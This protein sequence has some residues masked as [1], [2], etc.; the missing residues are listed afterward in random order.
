MMI[1]S[2]RGLKLLLV[3]SLAITALFLVSMEDATVSGA[4][5]TVDDDGTG[6]FRT[7]Q[8]AIDAANAGDT[9]SVADGTYDVFDVTK[10]VNIF[11]TGP[12]GCTI[13]GIG[14]ETPINITANNVN[15]SGFFI[16]FSG[17]HIY[18]NGSTIFK[19]YFESN[20]A[21]VYLTMGTHHS[22]IKNND[23]N[24]NNGASTSGI[25]VYIG[26]HN[27]TFLHNRLWENEYGIGLIESHNN[28]ISGN[29][30]N[31]S[32]ESGIILDDSNDTQITQNVI[33][34][35]LRG[36]HIRD[37]SRTDISSSLIHDNT[38]NGIHFDGGNGG[39][40][41]KNIIHDN[42]NNG[43]LLRTSFGVKIYNNSI[44][45]NDRGIAL[46][47]QSENNV[48][49]FNNI[50]NNVNYGV[51]DPSTNGFSINASYNW[52]GD[53]TGPYHVDDNPDGEGD[54]VSDDVEFITW[55]EDPI[56]V[57]MIISITENPAHGDYKVRFEGY[58]I[59]EEINF[60][61]WNSSIDGEFYKGT[62][63]VFRN[64]QLSVGTHLISFRVR[65]KAGNIWSEDIN[66][67][68]VIHER[69]MPTID[70]VSPKPALDTDAILFRGSGTDDGTIEQYAWRSSI[71][72]EFYNGT[73]PEFLYD[74]LSNGSHLIY[75]KVMDNFGGWSDEVPT[76]LMIQGRPQVFIEDISP[77]PALFGDEI[78]FT[79]RADDDGSITRIIWNSSISGTLS[80]GLDETIWND[81]LP[82]GEHLITIVAVDD[83]DV[84]SFE[85]SFTAI[86]TLKPE[87]F[88]DSISPETA[89]DTDVIHFKGHGTDGDGA[90][91]WFEW[92]S[93]L[94][95]LLYAG[96]DGEFGDS[97]LRNGTHE[98]TLRVMDNYGVWSDAVSYSITVFGKPI[99]RISTIFPNP[100]I[101]GR[102]VFF[103][104]SG[105]DE[106]SILQFAWRSN[107]DGEF[108]N[109]TE[110]EFYFANLSLGTH[111]IFFKVMDNDGIWSSEVAKT[112]IITSIP[113]AI[114]NDIS[115]NPAFDTDTITFNG[116]GT[117]DRGIDRYSWRSDTDGEFY[118]GTNDIIMINGLSNGTHMI[119]LAVMDDLGFWST[120][121]N[122]TL[123]IHGKPRAHIISVR[124]KPASPEDN[125][126]F[127]GGGTDDGSIVR[128]V[129]TSSIQGE[130]YN[131]TDDSFT[132]TS[133]LRGH[134]TISIKV[135]DD[136]GFWSD[137]DST[138]LIV[139]DIPIPYI[140][141]I[142]PNPA[143]HVET[144][145]FEGH[146][147]DNGNIERYVW[148]SDLDGE[149]Y[150]GTET[151]LSPFQM[152]EGF[153]AINLSYGTGGYTGWFS[154]NSTAFEG[155]R[156]ARS[157]DVDDDEFSWMETTFS[158]PG[159]LSFFWKVSSEE[160][161]HLRLYIDG[162]YTAQISGN[163]DWA[164]YVVTFED[165]GHTV[166]WSYEKDTS[167]SFGADAGYVD[168]I[169]Y[170]SDLR[171]Q[172]GTHTITLTVMDNEGFWSKT[173]SSQLVINGKPI[174]TDTKI[175]P[176]PAFHTDP[177]TFNATVEEDGNVT[178]YVWWSTR[179]GELYNGTESVITL[180][181]L[182]NGTH[183]ISLR[184]L[185]DF[186]VWSD[187]SN[188]TLS[189][190]GRPFAIIESISPN[191]A[192][193]NQILH[194]VG[195]ATDDGYI[196]TYLWESSID[197]E[198]YRDENPE[199]NISGLSTGLHTITLK[200]QDNKGHWSEMV[201]T[202]LD[203]N[204]IPWASFSPITPNPARD[205]DLISLVGTG[206]D[207][208]T[209]V[210]YRW[211]SN[212]DD[213]VYDGNQSSIQLDNLS[214]GSHMIYFKVQD[215]KG[216]WSTEVFRSVT[217]TQQPVAYIDLIDPRPA[218]HTDLIALRGHAVDDGDIVEY[219]W[220]S[221][222]HGIIYT[223]NLN[224]L[225]T[226]TLRNGSHLIEFR[227][228]DIY[229]FYSEWAGQTLEVN[230]I[231][232][233]TISSFDPSEPTDRDT[234]NFYGAAR[235]DG[236][237]MAFQWNSS[238]DGVIS[239]EKDF[240]I[241][242]MSNGTHII[243]LR[244]LDNQGLWSEE[245]S[246]IV[247][248][249]GHPNA[250]ISGIVPS[251]SNEGGKVW[252][253]GAASDDGTI[254]AYEWWSDQLGVFST[255]RTFNSTTLSNGT[256][257]ITFRAQDNGGLWSNEDSK[258]ITV[259]GV[260]RVTFMNITSV[261]I[262][263]G[264]LISFHGEGFDDKGTIQ[265]YS[266]SSNLVPGILSSSQTFE[267][268][269]LPNGTNIISFRVL[270]SDSV[271]S[272]YSTKE[273]TVN[274]I[275][276]AHIDSIS[277]EP[278]VETRQISFSGIG[279]DDTGPVAAY[280]WTSSIDGDIATTSQFSTT[281]LSVGDHIISFQVMDSDDVW[282]E[283]DTMNFRVNDIPVAEITSIIPALSNSGDKVSFFG[284]GV[285]DDADIVEYLWTSPQ[286][287]QIG[288]LNQFDY[289]G[290]SNGT[291]AITLRV[292][293]SKGIWSDPVSMTVTV[294]G[295]PYGQ[296]T[297][298]SDNVVIFGESIELS[299]SGND[300]GTIS[301]YTWTSSLSGVLYSGSQATL[302]IVL[303][304]VGTH[305][306]SLV[307]TDELGAES[308][309]VTTVVRVNG[310]PVAD[311]DHISKN[312]AEE[313]HRIF[314]RAIGSDDN[315]VV[316]YEWTSSKDGRLYEGPDAEF[317]TTNLTLGNHTISLRV[318][319][320]EGVWSP[321]VTTDVLIVEK[322]EDGTPWMLYAG[323]GAVVLILLLFI[324]FVVLPNRESGSGDGSGAG[325][326][327]GQFTGSMPPPPGSP[328]TMPGPAMG[329]QPQPQQ[330]QPQPQPQV[331][332]SGMG[333]PMGQTP[334][335][336]GPGPMVRPGAPMTSA[337]PSPP[338][339]IPPIVPLPVPSNQ[340]SPGQAPSQVQQPQP[341]QAGP[342]PGQQQ[343][344]QTP[345]QRDHWFCP[346]CGNKLD[347]KF[348]FCTKCGFK[349]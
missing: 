34:G 149:F 278:G 97:D 14:E 236:P 275:P 249:N 299:G 158:W 242:N 67:T 336:S 77:N 332:S 346:K 4:T 335:P 57:P 191:P 250:E 27:N 306:I 61:R 155:D 190:L 327:S 303:D 48:A 147:T 30:I 204:G 284:W 139:S 13:S 318:R 298:V 263:S 169:T 330:P 217:I 197:G 87:A 12:D 260:P 5:I 199:F 125:I 348:V 152:Y 41:S 248:V 225:N 176:S 118:N 338:G 238:I 99:S 111:S 305:T 96:P 113:V 170:S 120:E 86:I 145:I 219:Q 252:F 140:D 124:P 255:E 290:L 347:Q 221:S 293:D 84:W 243:T 328:G 334:P 153:E 47:T 42:G 308:D 282:S 231:P 148:Q 65:Q 71:D 43:I 341:G 144:I 302:E 212:I 320:D 247:P 349:R 237:I 246:V 132:A 37:S 280:R 11:G 222:L 196:I 161:D 291:H 1:H 74:G 135:Q 26:S 254:A 150:N 56:L 90:V 186:G 234:V 339:M 187:Y 128:Y 63:N 157:G 267:Y 119:Y 198:I 245:V 171:L 241:S 209:I 85:V 64:D 38:L 2:T 75:L 279:T 92:R 271:W 146:G 29:R 93:D 331:P 178:R 95:G 325:Q 112:L 167:I 31:G 226:T 79:G 131:G 116:T 281:G 322:E 324:I 70:E 81:S 8:D 223:G 329:A 72:G 166:R 88:I 321:I 316:W 283:I 180:S 188:F 292:R 235:D 108:M 18:G 19:N 39:T 98:I 164:Q 214:L 210:R 162:K 230:G 315:D 73:E 340:P 68:L 78:Q 183:T 319:D 194:F 288:S 203:I 269:N 59:G 83:K 66:T 265:A 345:P 256:H 297:D 138:L 50:Y 117:D 244:I 229:G 312:P 101:I 133:F 182:E 100:A 342:S 309:P 218:V 179:G 202:T 195:N 3:F 130:L 91:T 136:D 201:N 123:I 106:G 23:F 17:V 262:T 104:G 258:T 232:Y 7:I 276:G 22:M 274:G 143:Q 206:N 323:G 268:A 94:D 40:V 163:R 314:F 21:G 173:T 311:I 213:V 165:G 55:L 32:L 185:D 174:I 122:T 25:L 160:E 313:G 261:K 126:T 76:N 151:M 36:V 295:H 344:A 44:Y 184:V 9:I 211:R 109:G 233:A 343:P 286:D 54:E 227:A 89:L 172:N 49:Q 277:P 220:K 16:S 60:Y 300:D 239:T 45:Q 129:W 154:T 69:P 141:S 33:F 216:V 240:S 105:T 102:D 62:A 326:T 257:L 51:W 304:E 301:T 307:V 80:D 156:S 177:V 294:N 52:W 82:I 115:P 28:V 215:D 259:N 337:P 266:W 175:T 296:I 142:D 317:R 159:T 310:I 58:G 333:M 137:H 228:R 24:G 181:G 208:G 251:D 189:I 205:T 110:S 46:R 287:G 224:Y 35:N 207:D 53:D 107:L 289:I 10:T 193:D 134:H 121:V 264:D 192:L 168:A 200:V 20:V 15:M 114:I 272:T 6:D 127:T 253:Y 103:R 270:D 273:V 285:V